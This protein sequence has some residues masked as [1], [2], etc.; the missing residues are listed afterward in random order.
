MKDTRYI[1]LLALSAML[2]VLLAGCSV[3]S[4]DTEEETSGEQ[5]VETYYP[6]YGYTVAFSFRDISGNDLVAPL[7]S[8]ESDKRFNIHIKWSAEDSEYES[9]FGIVPMDERY[10]IVEAKED[11]TCEGNVTWYLI[12]SGVGYGETATFSIQCNTIFGDYAFHDITTWWK[13]KKRRY[14]FVSGIQHPICTKAAYAGQEVTPVESV[15]HIETAEFS[16]NEVH[17]LIDF[18]LDK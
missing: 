17:Y 1:L 2:A 18:I 5:T 4:L 12:H 7:A 9:D 8:M 11:G 16:R 6:P 15:L 10:N 13:E 3:G 14:R